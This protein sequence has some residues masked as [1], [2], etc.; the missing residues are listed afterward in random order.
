MTRVPTRNHWRVEVEW[1]DS[2]LLH[3]GWEPIED[4]LQR[5]EAVRCMS[6]GFVLADDAK[7]IVLASSVHGNEVTGVTII[8]KRAIVGR[9]R[10][11]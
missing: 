6:V 4:V 3:D 10:L 5:R 11:A 1:E 7:G 2:S 8:P 9:K